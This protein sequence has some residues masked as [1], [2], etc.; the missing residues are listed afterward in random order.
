MRICIL[1]CAGIAHLPPRFI[2]PENPWQRLAG[3]RISP[4]EK[5]TGDTCV[6]LMGKQKPGEK[7]PRFY[8]KAPL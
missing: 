5:F 6:A 1:K 4:P 2:A 7:I 8:R 3:F